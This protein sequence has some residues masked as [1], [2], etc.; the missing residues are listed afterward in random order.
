MHN[1]SGLFA[2]IFTL[3][4]FIVLVACVIYDIVNPA[5]V[6]VPASLTAGIT[7]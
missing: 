7:W 6:A 3:V 5:E 4:L 1:N 2:K